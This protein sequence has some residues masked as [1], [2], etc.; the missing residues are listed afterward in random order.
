VARS[1]N[2]ISVGDAASLMQRGRLHT[3]DG[4]IGGGVNH[5]VKVEVLAVD[6]LVTIQLPN[7]EIRRTAYRN[8]EKL[9]DS[10]EDRV[11]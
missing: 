11:S 1:P 5:G 6:S 9:G 10:R 7:G 8:L 4:V 3:G 2:V